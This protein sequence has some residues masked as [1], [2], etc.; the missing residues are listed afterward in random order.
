VHTIDIALAADKV[1]AGR[2]TPQPVQAAPMPADWC[3]VRSQPRRQSG[4]DAPWLA[5]AG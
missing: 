1:E 4:A 2:W 5:P 3:F